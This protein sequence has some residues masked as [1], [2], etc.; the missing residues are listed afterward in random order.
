MSDEKDD[1]ENS[2]LNEQ[3]RMLIKNGVENLDILD[4]EAVREF[5]K[6][7]TVAP[8]LYNAAQAKY[9]NPIVTSP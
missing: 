4:N 9:E 3:F 7:K 5:L 8:K 6:R 1:H 2:D